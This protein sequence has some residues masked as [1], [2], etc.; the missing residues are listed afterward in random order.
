MKNKITILGTNGTK[1]VH[2]GTTAFQ[3]D[4][5]NVIDAGN[6][7]IP[8]EAASAEV[9]TIWLTHSH[10]DHIADIAY[11]LDS[12]FDQRRVPL[13]LRGSQETLEAIKK[14]FLNNIIWPDFSQIRLPHTQ[15]MGLYY[16]PIDFGSSY[17]I[18]DQCSIKAFATDH[19]P[20]SC[21]YIVTQNE[22]SVLITSDTYDLSHIVKI[23]EED[24][25]ITSL[26]VECSFPSKMHVLAKESKHL[27][28]DLLFQGIKKL[29]NRSLKLYINH[30]KPL[31]EPQIQ[32]ELRLKKGVWD[33]KTL[34]DGEKIDF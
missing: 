5:L 7:L 31:C 29:E 30:I 34:K 6:I 23:V 11:I 12:Y 25:S 2:G 10:L 24:Q 4:A 32:E 1:G 9:E 22:S 18:S 16:E 3:I 20:G 27:T 8:L 14:H 26:V 15:L 21:G 17:K 33:V 13:K 28:P 19:I